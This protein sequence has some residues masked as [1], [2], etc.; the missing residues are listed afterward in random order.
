M[1]HRTKYICLLRNVRLD[2]EPTQI[3]ISY[4]EGFLSPEANRS[5]LDAEQLRLFSKETKNVWSHTAASPDNLHGVYKE[6]F[7]LHNLNTF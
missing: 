2:L 7:P 3:H 6:N 4:T 5:W 1:T